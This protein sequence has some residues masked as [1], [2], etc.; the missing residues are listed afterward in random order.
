[1]RCSLALLGRGLPHCESSYFC[2]RLLFG[3]KVQ[4]PSRGSTL[5]SKYRHSSTGRYAQTLSSVFRPEALKHMFLRPLALREAWARRAPSPA[6][7]LNRCW[8]KAAFPLV[9]FSCSSLSCFCVQLHFTL[10]IMLVSGGQQSA[11]TVIQFTGGSPEKLGATHLHN[12]FSQCYGLYLLY[13]TLHL[14]GC[15]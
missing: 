9:P 4:Q 3:G 15:L 11:Y 7:R 5:Q 13:C 8:A 1:M 12:C 6:L 14:S 10:S 2:S